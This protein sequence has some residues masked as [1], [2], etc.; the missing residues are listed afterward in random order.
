MKEKCPYCKK[1]FTE[2]TPDEW[3]KC[4]QRYIADDAFKDL[5]K[6]QKIVEMLS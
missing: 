2:H 5:E 1:K 3:L 6:L 4:L